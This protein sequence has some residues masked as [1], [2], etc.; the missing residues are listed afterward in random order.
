MKKL[1]MPKDYKSEK[2]GINIRPYLTQDDIILIG[3][4]MVSMNN[5]VEQELTLASS[6]IDRCTDIDMDVEDLDVDEMMMSGLWDEVREHVVNVSDVWEYVYHEQDMDI[7]I[8]RF[9]NNTL[10]NML[11][12]YEK[13]ANKYIKRLPKDGE[14]DAVISA[15]PENLRAVL[16]VAKE[17]GNAEIIKGA[18]KMGE[19]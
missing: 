11:D 10:P 3:S 6:V 18:F 13:L 7:A 19:R 5:T 12:K 16:D 4:A 9:F 15:L 8:A 14:W 2:F 1:E 17:D